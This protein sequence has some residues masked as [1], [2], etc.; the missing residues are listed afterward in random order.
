MAPRE[1]G[2]LEIPRK[3]WRNRPV[4]HRVIDLPV[5]IK[6]GINLTQGFTYKVPV[7][8][9]LREAGVI[10]LL[11]NLH[12]FLVGEAGVKKI[13]LHVGSEKSEL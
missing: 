13:A 1:C 10:S 4:Q 3:R 2:G 5:H 6:R 12:H 7:I 11:N 9:R 8:D